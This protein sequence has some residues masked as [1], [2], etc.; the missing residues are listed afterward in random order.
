[1]QAATFEALKKKVQAAKDALGCIVAFEE[2]KEKEQ[3]EKD[4]KAT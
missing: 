3:A 1:M 4:A 2:L